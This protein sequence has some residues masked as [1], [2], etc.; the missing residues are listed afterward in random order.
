MLWYKAWREGRVRFLLSVAVLVFLCISSMNRAH[1]GFP[2]PEA[3]PG[4]LTHI[5]IDKV[6][7]VGPWAT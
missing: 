7:G 6:G 2:P 3:P 5:T 4:Y 1:T